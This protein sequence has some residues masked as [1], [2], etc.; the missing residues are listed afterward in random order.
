MFEDDALEAWL[1]DAIKTL[2]Q[3]KPTQICLA[4]RTGNG[5]TLTAYYMCDAED[6]AL[7]ASHIQAD[8]M[9]DVLEANADTL[10]GILGGDE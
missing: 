5:E 6:K 9:L 3:V 2:I 10:R 7:I 8:A 4:A 1:E